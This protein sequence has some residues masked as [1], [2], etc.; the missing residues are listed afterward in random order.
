MTGRLF[1]TQTPACFISQY[2]IEATFAIFEKEYLEANHPK[3]WT[4]PRKYV[5]TMDHQ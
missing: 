5:P 2:K 3:A 1:C 4:G